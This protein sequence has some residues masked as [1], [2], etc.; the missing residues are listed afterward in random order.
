[1]SA[2]DAP[3]ELWVPGWRKSW[4]SVSHS[5][6]QGNAKKSVSYVAQSIGPM[7]VADASRVFDVAD[8]AEVRKRSMLRYS[9]GRLDS[10]AGR[11]NSSEEARLLCIRNR[12]SSFFICAAVTLRSDWTI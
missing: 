2:T 4:S 3:I 7:I 1:M 8:S 10:D 11:P 9:G 6:G 5:V 12:V